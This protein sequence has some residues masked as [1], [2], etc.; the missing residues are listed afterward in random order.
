MPTKSASDKAGAVNRRRFI[1]VMGGGAAAVGLAACADDANDGMSPLERRGGSV[2]PLTQESPGASESPDSTSPAV[3]TRRVSITPELARLADLQPADASE[4]H[5]AYAPNVPPP[6]ART[7]QRIVEFSIDVVEGVCEIDPDNGVSV[8]MWGF[9]IAG[10]S[11]TTCGVPGPIM[12]ARVGDLAK[13]TVNNSSDNANAHNIDFH[14]V[15]GMHGGAAG[16]TVAAGESATIYARLLYPGAFMYHCAFGD[17]PM[18]IAHGMYGM[19]IVDPEEPLPEVDHEWSLM[20][21]EWYVGEPDADGMAA[22]D[23]DS[24]RREEPRYVTFNG[25][26]NALIGDNALQMNVGERA[27]IYMV[28]EGLNLTSN[29]H[30]IGSHWDLVYP[31]AATHPINQ[32]IRGSQSTSVVAG[33]GTV[34][35]MI[36]QVPSTIVL[37][38]H[39]L[40]RTFYKGCI[41]N[42]VISGEENGS[43]FSESEQGLADAEANE[44]E[45]APDAAPGEV[46]IPPGAWDPANADIAYSPKVLTISAGTTVTWRNTDTMFHTVTSGSSNGQAGTSDGLFESGE[47][48]PGETFQHTFDKA[49]TFDYFCTPHPWMMGQVVVT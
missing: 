22:F 5:M 42:V 17:V 33:G 13:I 41:G 4:V 34:V 12:R 18:H 19:F 30:P 8:D 49:G 47:V 7:D 2:A 46:V 21:S 24:V 36:G 45:A 25:R 1:Q 20:Q 14:A 44:Q 43:I 31:E 39:A 16:T 26:T 48:Q 15:T 11:D 37:V 29:F 6:I 40:S 27:R 38:D 10:D 35:E 3:D 23:P 28:N 32:V 9:L